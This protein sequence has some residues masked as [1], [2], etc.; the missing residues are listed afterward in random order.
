MTIVLLYYNYTP[1]QVMNT[2]RIKLSI[3]LILVAFQAKANNFTNNTSGN[4]GSLSW[5]STSQSKTKYT[6]SAATVV[7]LNV[8][9][10]NIDTLII[11][12]ELTL[13]SNKS[14]SMNATGIIIVNTGG[15][16]TGG[17]ANSNFG[18]SSGSTGVIN[19][20]WN[21]SST[22]FGPKTAS[23]NTNG[24]QGFTPLS[25]NILN[26][27]IASSTNNQI[28]LTWSNVFNPYFAS[29]E[30]Q[31]S[32]DGENFNT[33]VEF[34]ENSTQN[35]QEYKYTDPNTYNNNKVIYRLKYTETS[36]E[37]TFSKPLV[38]F[39]KNDIVQFKVYPNPAVG[40]LNIQF[41]ENLGNNN[42]NIKIKNTN[43][44]VVYDTTALSDF[45]YIDVSNFTKG[46][47]VIEI[48]STNTLQT[49]KITIQ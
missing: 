18:F 46:I 2:Q 25:I 28:E 35:V 44:Q 3:L 45:Q 9:V 40:Q 10:S 26:F 47:Y 30:L 49:S 34:Y 4:W 24:F 19:G 36:G 31:T 15:K 1:A 39:F 5:T 21:G 23:L 42:L 29:C 17:S 27:E 12:G 7:S 22:V 32:V 20:P 38:H 8:N 48:Q 6:V 33:V 37:I 13:A 11:N 14:I 43:G 41:S 16:I